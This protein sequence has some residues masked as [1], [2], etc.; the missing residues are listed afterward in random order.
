[1][2][3]IQTPKLPH[4]IS[5]NVWLVNFEGFTSLLVL[6]KPFNLRSFLE[7]DWMERF[8]IADKFEND[9]AVR[10]LKLKLGLV[11]PKNPKYLKH[12]NY[13]K[14]SKKRW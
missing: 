7:F 10:L 8:G 9:K 2:D 1:M 6:H 11:K 13:N 14:R 3:K 5:D 12:K 4:Q